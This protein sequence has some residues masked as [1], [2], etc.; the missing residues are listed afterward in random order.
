L[1]SEIGQ[2]EAARTVLERLES[3]KYPKN[4]CKIAW[5]SGQFVGLNQ[6]DRIPADPTIAK[7]LVKSVKSALCKGGNGYLGWRACSYSKKGVDYGGNCFRKTGD[8]EDTDE[9]Q[10]IMRLLNLNIESA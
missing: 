6:G 7:L 10:R 1:D 2:V 8:A 9:Y 5:A 4:I 3:G